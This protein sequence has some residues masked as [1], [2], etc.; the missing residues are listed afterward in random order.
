MDLSNP[1]SPHELAVRMA[2]LVREI[3]AP[4]PIEQVLAEVTTAAVELIPGADI[5]G[6]CS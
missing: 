5:A 1:N 6:G 2:E 3:G 4:R